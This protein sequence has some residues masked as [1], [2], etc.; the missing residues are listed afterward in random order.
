M[1]VKAKYEC[2]DDDKLVARLWNSKGIIL[3]SF[4]ISTLV[5]KLYCDDKYMF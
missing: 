2:A 4:A 5:I 1:E 3:T